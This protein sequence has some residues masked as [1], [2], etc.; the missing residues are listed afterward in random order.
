MRAATR[1]RAGA[2]YSEG[3][4]RLVG[5]VLAAQVLVGLVTWASDVA[6]ALTDVTVG[7]VHPIVMLGAVGL[8]GIATAR[9]RDAEDAAGAWGAIAR[10]Q[11]FSLV[12]VIAGIGL[13]SM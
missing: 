13:A 7:V 1:A 6:G 10:F 11:G 4:P 9:A 3:F 12:A 2:A 8:A 5:L